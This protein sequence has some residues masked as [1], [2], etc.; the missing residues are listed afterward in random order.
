MRHLEVW[1]SIWNTT[2][3]GM[4]RTVAALIFTALSGTAIGGQEPQRVQIPQPVETPKPTDPQAPAATFRAGVDLVRVNAIVRD[5]KGRFV[6]DL[7]SRDFEVF[8]GGISRPITDFRRDEAGVSVAML[9]D[10]SGSME[11]SLGFAREAA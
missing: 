2:V 10:I 6:T 11:A 3:R 5:K 4:R 9:F 8:D 7:T 1:Q